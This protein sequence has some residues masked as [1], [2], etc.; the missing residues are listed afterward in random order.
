MPSRTMAERLAESTWTGFTK[1]HKL[2]LEDAALRRALARFDK[3]DETRHAPWAE[4]LA[5]LTEQLAKQLKLQGT[6]K[7]EL[8]DKDFALVKGLLDALLGEAVALQKRKPAPVA[9]EDEADSPA[10]L[11]SKM[12]PLLRELR[13]GEVRMH[14]LICLAGKNT[15]V[16]IM[17]RRIS[18]SQ[19]KLLATAVEAT[20]G[21]KYIVAEC[22]DEAKVLTFAVLSPAAQ[23]AKRLRRALLEQTGLRLKVKVRGEDGLEEL[24]GEDEEPAPAA[25]QAAADAGRAPAAAPS[26]AQLA[27]AQRLALLEPRLAKA[28]QEEHPEATKLR[29]TS[30]DASEKA[31]QKNYG[32]ALKALDTLER[33]LAP[34]PTSG[35]ADPTDPGTA[36][37]A[38]MAA[39][40][41][42]IKE[43]QAA[44]HPAAQNARLK[45]GE[46]GVLAGKRAYVQAHA[47]LDAVQALLDGTAAPSATTTATTAT[48]ATAT[49]ATTGETAKPGT[50]NVAFA[51]IKLR[52]NEAKQSLESDLHGLRETV[53]AEYGDADTVQDAQ[54]ILRITGRFNEGLADTLDA[55]YNAADAPRQARLRARAAEIAGSYQAYLDTDP[56]VAHIQQNPFMALEIR[57]RLSAPLAQLRQHLSQY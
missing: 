17:R 38:R 28:L 43:A 32:A 3:T 8:G 21:H 1:K 34:A 23:L 9:E 48:A 41:T 27:Y 6:R 49:T 2:E 10:L 47:L 29:A 33:L 40:V 15:A 57:A 52:W 56:L 53:L 51:K 30:G 18:T 16:L 46:A 13:K 42:G 19:R 26:A 20:G 50:K 44:G 55:L 54:K 12:L 39:L 24:D 11:T 4:A 35:D 37:K 14:A 45:A 5:E 7:K 36:F 31:A 22:F 25:Q